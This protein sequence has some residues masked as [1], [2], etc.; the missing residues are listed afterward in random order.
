MR[1]VLLVLAMLLAGEARAAA[2]CAACA[3]GGG[4][5]QAVAPPGWDGRTRLRLLVFLH[6]WMMEGADIAADAGIRAAAGRMG[7]LLV[8]PDGLLRTWSHRGSPSQ[9]R[10]DVAFIRAV[11]ADV[12]QR[13]PVDGRSVIAA[14]F[15]QGASMVWDLACY[16][17]GDFSAFL[18]F[19][20]GFWEPMPRAC[21]SGAVS[22]RHVHGRDDPVVPMAGRALFGPYRQADIRRGFAVWVAEDRCAG[23]PVRLAVRGG[24]DCESWAGCTGGR[25]LQLCV[26]A[27]GHVLHAADVEDGLRWAVA[28]Q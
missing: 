20:G 27:G 15:S 2:P 18:P 22:L 24:L 7:F 3:A 16:A 25:R 23:R 17:A 11:V 5:Y 26:R 21:G 19:S 1:W 6:G 12:K 10:D 9:A 8:A 4:T 14:G 13:W 28:G